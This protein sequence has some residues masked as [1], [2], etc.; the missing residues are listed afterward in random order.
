MFESDDG[1]MLPVTRQKAGR[2]GMALP[3]GMVKPPAGTDSARVMEVA[4]RSSLFRVSQV[5][6]AW[7]ADGIAMQ[8]ATASAGRVVRD[9]N[10]KVMGSQLL[11]NIRLK[12]AARRLRRG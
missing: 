3:L 6:A 4:E 12:R 7:A 5:W 10:F 2:L 1:L 8:A 9:G 11:L